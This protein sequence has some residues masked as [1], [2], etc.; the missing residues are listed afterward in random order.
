MYNAI[1]DGTWHFD[2]I[3]N[4]ELNLEEPGKFAKQQR[5][6][7]HQPFIMF[8][9]HSYSAFN[10]KC[11]S[12]VSST[13]ILYIWKCVDIW[14]ISSWVHERY[15]L[16]LLHRTFIIA[17][18]IGSVLESY[19][20]YCLV[21]SWFSSDL[22]WDR[23]RQCA[24]RNLCSTLDDGRPHFVHIFCWVVSLSVASGSSF[25]SATLRCWNRRMAYSYITS[26]CIK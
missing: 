21:S 26:C 13:M 3:H 23:R 1:D 9:K 11:I 25:P 20:R 18:F 7:L 19:L 8:A 6:V 16:H 10:Q 14:H 15:R 24:N 17:A 5:S 22:V 12:Q 2:N 4:I